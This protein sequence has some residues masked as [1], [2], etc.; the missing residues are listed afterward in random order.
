MDPG[1]GGGALETRERG[2]N[3]AVDGKYLRREEENYNIV[4]SKIEQ[5]RSELVR[6]KVIEQLETKGYKNV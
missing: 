1:Q 5:V 4:K 6:R 2:G 3:D